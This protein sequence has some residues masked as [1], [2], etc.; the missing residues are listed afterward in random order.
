MLWAYVEL[1]KGC[2]VASHF[3]DSEQIAYVVR[4]KLLWRLGEEGTDGFSE[5]VVEG[6]TVIHL[7]SNV[8]HSVTALE[9]AVVLD[10]LSP[11]GEMGVD[12]QVR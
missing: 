2:H 3:H 9:D 1:A 6:G 5:V 8:P 10:V 11:P 12:R 4:G 7:P